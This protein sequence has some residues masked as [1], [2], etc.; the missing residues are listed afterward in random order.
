[1]LVRGWPPDTLG[2]ADSCALDSNAQVRER[3]CY[4]YSHARG[5]PNA[6]L[7]VKEF[8][9]DCMADSEA[10]ALLRLAMARIRLSAR[11]SSRVE[12]GVQ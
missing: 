12:S 7:T 4:D 2:R 9:R 8:E 10:Q 11:L 3:V 1:M 6:L 5:N